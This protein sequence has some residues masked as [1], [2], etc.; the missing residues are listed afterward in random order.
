MNTKAMRRKMNE[1]KKKEK[2]YGIVL[3]LGGLCINWNKADEVW[4]GTNEMEANRQLKI[5]KY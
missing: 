1:Y 5:R 2:D 4:W 3:C